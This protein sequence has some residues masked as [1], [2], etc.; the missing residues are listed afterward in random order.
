MLRKAKPN[1]IFKKSFLDIFLDNDFSFVKIALENS[2]W[3]EMEI[4]S[5]PIK[6]HISSKE[7]NNR[8]VPEFNR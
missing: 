3:E 8:A 7:T 6:A 4:G 5:Y 1:G 2:F